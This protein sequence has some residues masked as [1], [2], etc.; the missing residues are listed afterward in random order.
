MPLYV[1]LYRFTDQG[2][3]TIK[4]SPKRVREVS[5]AVQKMGGKILQVV[6]T[7]GRYDLVVISEAPTDEI[8]L[9]A[10]VAIL[11]AGNAVAETLHAYS[12]EEFEKILSKI[13]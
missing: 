3:K 7:T 2:R 10:G 4:D 5:A 13:P 1:V 8:A 12:V 11:S 6:Y 9:R